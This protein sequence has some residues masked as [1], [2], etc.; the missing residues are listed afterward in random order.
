MITKEEK[1][2]LI[3]AHKHTLM[4]RKYSLELDVL[5]ENAVT[6]PNSS[7]LASL[8]NQINE[9]DLQSAALAAE[10]DSVNAQEA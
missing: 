4:A 6:A 8:Q 5:K 1:L 10:E 3:A 7:T 2:Q 9:I